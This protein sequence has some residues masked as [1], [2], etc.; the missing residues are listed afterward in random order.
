MLTVLATTLRPASVREMG[1]RPAGVSPF[2]PGLSRQASHASPQ[3]GGKSA[4]WSTPNVRD[5]NGSPGHRG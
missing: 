4:L 1:R 3:S 5:D 2:L